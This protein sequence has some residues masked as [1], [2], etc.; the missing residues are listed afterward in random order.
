[1]RSLLAALLCLCFAARASDYLQELAYAAPVAP[2]ELAADIL[3]KLATL[4]IEAF[5]HPDH[6][7]RRAEWIE[8]AF[9]LSA[10]ARHPWRRV[11]GVVRA[12]HTDSDAGI[13][14]SSLEARLDVLSLRCR[15]VRAM[16]D[17]NPARARETFEQIVLR[18]PSLTCKDAMRYTVDDY[19]LLLD[20][21]YPRTLTAKELR[22]GRYLDILERQLRLIDAP[23]KL[24][25]A[26]RMLLRLQLPPEDFTRLLNAYSAAFFRIDA[27]DRA[28]TT[29]ANHSLTQATFDLIK[30]SQQLGLSV[31]PLVE[32]MRSYFIRHLKAVRCA[33]SADPKGAGATLAN[34][35]DLFNSNLVKLAPHLRPISAQDRIP[36]R[37]EGEAEVTDLWSTPASRPFLDRL[38]SFR[39]GRQP[40]GEPAWEQSVRDFRNDLETWKKNSD[41]PDSLI[42][43]QLCFAYLPLIEMTP[44]GPLRDSLVRD[45]IA[46]LASSSMQRD[47]PPEWYWEFRRLIRLHGARAHELEQIEDEIRNSGNTLM[48]F[49]L[50]AGQLLGK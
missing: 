18:I 42:F 22:E 13:L 23:A 9:Q 45:Y 1:M 48:R 25:P 15:A 36:L 16:L 6:R 27:D 3:I 5:N 38:R 12:S 43:H 47:S 46:I 34:V 31:T 50:A 21:I 32:G 35:L 44:L 39:L 37:A 26:A 20:E 10:H 4:P 41:L 40:L 29:G 7:A 24:D 17:L 30:K 2:P 14:S 33:D 49:L 8:R 28:F 11:A 19:Y